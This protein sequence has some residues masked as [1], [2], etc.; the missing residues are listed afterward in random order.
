[1]LLWSAVKA[2]FLLRF[3]E[4]KQL[5]FSS[6]KNEET[7]A[8]SVN[9]INRSVCLQFYEYNSTC[10]ISMFEGCLNITCQKV[11]RFQKMHNR[12]SFYGA[13]NYLDIF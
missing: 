4:D 8:L 3:C 5:N 10:D 11:P 6:L 9:C 1:M 12:L 13:L 2:I 7:R